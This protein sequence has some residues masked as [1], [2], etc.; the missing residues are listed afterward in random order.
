MET[1]NDILTIQT[2]EFVG[3]QYILAGI[4][5]RA[6]AFLLDMAIRGL[7][8][9]CL[10]IV[11]ILLTKLIS[12]LDPFGLLA[13]LSKNWI[14]AILFLAYAIVDLGYFIFFEAIWSG[15]TPGKRH[16]RLRVIR[17]NG[18]SIGWLDSTV[19]NILRII[20][21][22]AGLYPLGLIIMFISKRNQRIGDYAAGTVVIVER[23]QKIPRNRIRLKK[24]ISEISPEIEMRI[25]TLGPQQY[26]ILKSFLQRRQEMDQKSRHELARLLAQRLFDRWGISAKIEISY[27]TFLEQVVEGYELTRRA[28]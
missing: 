12:A 15:Q 1:S 11:G 24:D 2:P 18:Q 25:S 7:L 9:F 19:R 17:A 10:F 26:Q 20:D 21:M 4:G 22:L 5:T 6:T 23:R 8:I 3:F 28:I 13:G 16:Q 27:E 14:L